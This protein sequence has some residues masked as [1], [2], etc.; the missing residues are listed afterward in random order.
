MQH[1]DAADYVVISAFAVAFIGLLVWVITYA[2]WTRGDWRRTR[3]GRHMMAFRTS[4]VLFMAL[5]VTDNIWSH[6]PGRDVLRCIVVP[7][8]A[9]SVLDGLR[10]LVSAQ[11]ERERSRTGE[12]VPDGG[13]DVGVDRPVAEEH[14]AGKRLTSDVLRPDHH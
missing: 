5:G 2:T 7:L 6:Y 4:L 14:R 13:Q 10:V 9:A 12:G 8:F 1:L 3:E 11:L